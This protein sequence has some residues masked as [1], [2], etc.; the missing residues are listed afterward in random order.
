VRSVAG[1]TK[2]YPVA[3]RSC[4]NTGVS[5][6]IRI[7]KCSTPPAPGVADGGGHRKSAIHE[8]CFQSPLAWLNT[9]VLK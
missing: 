9:Q 7:E 6:A 5:L 1:V 2:R 3:S 8:C 4:S